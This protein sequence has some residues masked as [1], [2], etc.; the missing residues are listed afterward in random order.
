MYYSPLIEIIAFGKALMYVISFA[1][2]DS[3]QSTQGSNSP[4]LGIAALGIIASLVGIYYTISQIRYVKKQTESLDKSNSS[5][6]SLVSNIDNK[7]SSVFNLVSSGH[8]GNS[9]SYQESTDNIM[10]YRN[11]YSGITERP[12]TSL[13]NLRT[14]HYTAEKEFICKKFVE[15]ILKKYGNPENGKIPTIYLLI[16]SGSTVFPIFRHLCDTYWSTSDRSVLD[17]IKIITNNLSG[18]NTL[19]IFGKRDL[20]VN[21]GLIFPCKVLPGKIESQYNAVLSSESINHLNFTI[22]K[23]REYHKDNEAVFISVLTG[24]YLSI[25][26]G[27]LW[28]GN[29]HGAMKDAYII[30]SD[31]IYIL[32]PL[33]KIFNKDVKWFENTQNK[34]SITSVKHYSKLTNLNLNDKHDDKSENIF[35]IEFFRRKTVRE[36]I[37][38]TEEDKIE[39][40]LP[41]PLI[42][43]I[44]NEVYLITTKR[45]CMNDSLYP[46][47]LT[48]YFNEITKEL[49]NI[50]LKNLLI[51]DFSPEK[52]SED[53]MRQLHFRT[54]QREDIFFNYEFPHA[55]MRAQMKG[56]LNKFYPGCSEENLNLNSAN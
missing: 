19:Q 33:G 47:H 25:K 40:L 8:L 2:G 29:Y 35:E 16:D 42:E 44:K 24:N 51:Y 54:S 13:F 27:L 53:V 18:I 36:K 20:S 22:G 37:Q 10:L 34:H 5:F 43:G 46:A 21:S 49:H 9:P 7:I 17:N 4:F 3:S 11:L 26:D 41:L 48:N 45:I 30:N 31:C 23:L 55:A 6:S 15:H 38:L 52:D 12:N 56:E 39:R 14:Q 32:S 28:R 50:F 1:V